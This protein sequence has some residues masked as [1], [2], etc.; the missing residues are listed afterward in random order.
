M[1]SAKKT[2]CHLSKNEI[3]ASREKKGHIGR[4]TTQR[5]REFRKGDR[6]ERRTVKS[7]I[8]PATKTKG[9]G[10]SGETGAGSSS[11]ALVSK[12]WKKKAWV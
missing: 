12:V 8:D 6:D 7:I 5:R 4:S 1:R 2:A 11:D 10:S 9:K 3:S